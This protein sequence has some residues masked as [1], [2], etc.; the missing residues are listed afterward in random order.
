MGLKDPL[1]FFPISVS[2]DSTNLR[3]TDNYLY[4]INGL[5]FLKSENM[6]Y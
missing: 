1:S 6:Q 3:L 2:Y 5:R 4:I